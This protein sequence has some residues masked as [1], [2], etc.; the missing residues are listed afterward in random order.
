MRD[1]PRKQI[2]L[3][4]DHI[5][6]REGLERLLNIG[7]EFVVCE[8]AGDAERGMEM[9]RDMQPDGVVV[10]IQLPGTDGIELTKQLLQEFPHLV[11]VTLSACEEP[12]M[13][14][15]AM[16]AG[17]M[18]YVAKSEGIEALRA[19]LRNA[20]NHKRTFSLLKKFGGID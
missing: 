13:A 5:L 1:D 3:I 9:V 10:D 8:D 17:A 12:E 6:M 15:R 2:V 18:A 16:H 11:V 19:A 4:D 7:D 14:A 20:F